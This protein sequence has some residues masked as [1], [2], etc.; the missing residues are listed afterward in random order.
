VPISLPPSLR[1]ENDP[2]E[3]K[4]ARYRDMTPEERLEVVAAVCRAAAALLA[5]N[6]NREQV[7]AYQAPLPE[8]TV[9]ALARLVTAGRRD[10]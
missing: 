10:G 6:P 9:A 8:S 2:D 5:I 4:H 3:E 7:L 1:A